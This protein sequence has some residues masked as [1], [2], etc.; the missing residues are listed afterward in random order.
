LQCGVT[1]RRVHGKRK[2][3]QEKSIVFD[4]IVAQSTGVHGD[5]QTLACTLSMQLVRGETG[6]IGVV[7]CLEDLKICFEDDLYG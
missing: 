6:T 2:R 7:M 4:S 3:G 5:E 1:L